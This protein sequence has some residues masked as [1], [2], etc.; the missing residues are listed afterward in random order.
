MIACMRQLLLLVTTAAVSLARA[1]EPSQIYYSRPSDEKRRAEADHAFSEWPVGTTLCD[2][3]DG[4]TFVV[5]AIGAKGT[6]DGRVDRY[7]EVTPQAGGPTRKVFGGRLTALC[8]NA[9]LD[10]DAQADHAQVFFTSEFKIRVRARGG[11]L[12]I[13]PRGGAYLSRVGGPATAVLLDTKVAGVPLLKVGSRPEACSDY[14]D[15]YVS[16]DQAGAPHLALAVEGLAD[17]PT[18]VTP[19][20][21]FDPRAGTATVTMKYE[22]EDD[23][24]RKEVLRYRRVNGVY[25]LVK[26]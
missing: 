15:Y 12:D 4:A 6:L 22:N 23:K 5:S 13:E 10:G 2:V 24:P 26:R 14:G 3:D 17:P 21:R 20:L 9:D 8:F 7:Y 18:H 1:D 19:T 11:T 16:F 25:Q